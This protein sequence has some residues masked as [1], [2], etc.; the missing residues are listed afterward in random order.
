MVSVRFIVSLPLGGM[1]ER[2]PV[3]CLPRRATHSAPQ[4]RRQVAHAEYT[5][6]K[7]G[8][9]TVADTFRTLA[10]WSMPALRHVS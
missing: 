10:S 5:D 2:G 7:G 3:F 1:R 6:V 9:M 4:T 8:G